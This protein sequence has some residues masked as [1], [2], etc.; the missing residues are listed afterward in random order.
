LGNAGVDPDKEFGGALGM[1]R[2]GADKAQR[3]G[4]GKFILKT[5]F[6][7]VQSSHMSGRLWA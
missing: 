5:A 2:K 6:D 4:E 7:R 3:E 1:N